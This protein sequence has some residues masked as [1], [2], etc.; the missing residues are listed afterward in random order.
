[1]MRQHIG[2]PAK[3]LVKAGDYVEAGQ[4]IAEPA[5][6]LSLPVHASISGKVLEANDKFIMV[7]KALMDADKKRKGRANG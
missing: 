4:L 6:G 5:D 1:M 7:D 3:P 2:A